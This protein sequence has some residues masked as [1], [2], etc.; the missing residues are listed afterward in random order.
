[1][2]RQR[3]GVDPGSAGTPVSA[4][5]HDATTAVHRS[6]SSA[7]MART[8]RNHAAYHGRR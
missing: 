2:S 8:H 3:A 7:T 6:P 1:M 5:T 4:S